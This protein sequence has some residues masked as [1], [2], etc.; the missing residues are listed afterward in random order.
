MSPQILIDSEHRHLLSELSW[1]I[2]FKSGKPY[3]RSTRKY[4]HH[5]VL[6]AK[7]G[8]EVDH[9][10]G[11]ALNNRRENLRYVTHHQNQMNMSRHRDGS[12]QFKGVF[13]FKRDQCWSAQICRSGKRYHLGYFADEREAAQAY[14]TAAKKLHKK[15][16]KTNFR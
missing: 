9:I 7:K 13:W 15:F 3:V 12:S 5:F 14:D 1:N 10:D 6:P 11:N 2:V 8:F 4:L 16:A